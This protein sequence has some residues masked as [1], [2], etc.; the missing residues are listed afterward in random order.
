[1]TDFYINPQHCTDRRVPA[2]EHAEW[3]DQGALIALITDDRFTAERLNEQDSRGFTV[4]HALAHRHRSVKAMLTAVLNAGPNLNAQDVEGQ[5]ALHH[6]V[7]FR[8]LLVTKALIGAGADL[9]VQDRRGNTPFQIAFRAGA[10]RE[11]VARCLMAAGADLT[12]RNLDGQMALD[13]EPELGGNPCTNLRNDIRRAIVQ[14]EQAQLAAVA[15]ERRAPST[16]TSR[17]RRL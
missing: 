5:T 13:H 17:P 8:N 12:V 7:Y 2:I 11:N 16:A 9:N 10:A 15:D 1:M 6:A 14:Q 3:G 4:L